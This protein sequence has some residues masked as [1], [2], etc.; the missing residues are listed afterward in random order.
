[1]TILEDIISRVEE[2]NPIHAKKIR[3]N[4][5]GQNQEFLNKAEN[6]LK[7]YMQFL[8]KHGKDLDYAIDCYLKLID[9]MLYETI[10]FMTSKE[11]S[12]SSFQDVNTRIYDNPEVME[13]HMQGL[14][15][16]QFLW[17]QHYK[18][19]E[20]FLEN[21]PKHQDKTGNY[22]EVGAGHGIF[23]NSAI[24]LF[25]KVDSF[26]ALDIS[27]SSIEIAKNFVDSSKVRFVHS[28]ILKFEEQD[29]FDFITMGEVLEHVENPIGLLEKLKSLL[30][31]NGITFI[32]T[33]TNAPAIDH[34]YLFRNAEEIREV[35][36][37]SGFQ[38]ISEIQVPSEDMT[39]EEAHEK[40]ISV[41][42][43]AFLKK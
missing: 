28:D 43:G 33:P 20:F 3:K 18:I 19:L 34:I 42:Y 24:D 37:K 41:M 35:I 36:R 13:Y 38:I 5:S 25:S 31:D 16:S 39:A 9:D 15:L 14:L 26:T 7:D 4:I 32:T 27:K 11:Y 1:M 21:A 30:N 17:I 10:R 29:T 2:L 12:N 6:F 22:L 40:G 8:T 23:L